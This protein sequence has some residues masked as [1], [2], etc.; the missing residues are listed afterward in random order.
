MIQ[1][2]QLLKDILYKRNIKIEEEI[3]KF[4]Y[5]SLN[6]LTEP[7][8][9]KT[10]EIATREIIKAIENKDKIFIYGDGDIDGIGGV[11]LIIKFLK[12]KNV[13]FNYYLTHRLEDYEIEETFVNYL[14]KEKYKLLIL[15]DCGIS[16]YKFLKRCADENIK[17]IVIDH[18]QTDIEKLPESHI[19]IHPFFSSKDIDFSAT[20]LSFKLFQNLTSNYSNFTFNSY[21]SIAGLATLSENVDL[22]GDNRIFVKEMLKDL[23]NSTINGLNLIVS[24]YLRENK[25]ESEDIKK[26]IN[27]KLN[28][29]GRFG[30]PEISLNL[31][32]EENEKEIEKLLKEIEI[33]DRKRYQVTKKTMKA[34]EN[35]KSFESRFII[36]DDFP[37][38]LCGI[39]ASRLVERYNLPFLI[40]SRKDNIVKGSGRSP[41]KFNLYENM[42]KIKNKFLSFGG[43]KNAIGF[44][45]HIEKKDEIEE[46]WK[47]LR[48]F[49]VK[50]KY[51]DALLGIENIK[52]EIFEYLE[53]LKPYG[54]GNPAPIFLSKNVIIKKIKKGEKNKFWAAKG[55]VIFECET[56]LL[57]ELEEGEKTIFYTPEFEKKDGYYKIYLKIKNFK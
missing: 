22:T 55:D 33:L 19:Y 31:L 10:I 35:K 11:F 16:S 37:E 27:P 29:P 21:I 18:H 36:L 47:D 4:L 3:I 54:K 14:L 50:E 44:K 52:P 39:I 23:R 40:M 2:P 56:D 41:E 46:Y 26:I 34:I 45:F 24:K 9:V 28:S 49:E 20:G 12:D 53:L 7:S 48:V 42:K 32:L 17:I 13:E 51:Y 38:S 6:D 1:I 8:V 25:I 43:H 57:K 5:P 15:I 30:K